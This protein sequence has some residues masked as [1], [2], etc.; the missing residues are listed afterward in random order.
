[1]SYYGGGSDSFAGIKPFEAMDVSRS[2]FAV[3]AGLDYDLNESFL[4][5][6]AA[7]YEDFSDFGSN[8]SWK[9]NTRYKL[10]KDI[11][12]RASASTGFRAPSLHQRY[13]TLTQYIIVAP[14]P[15]PQLQGTFANDSD[16]VRGLGVPNLEAETS[17]NYSVGVTG[18]AGK[19]SFSAD[20]YQISVDNR[21]LFSS[22]IGYDETAGNNPVE[23]ILED[24]GIKALQFFINAVNTK[25]TGADIVAGYNNVNLGK[26]K[27]GVNLAM[28]F[29]NTEMDGKVAN[30]QVLKE[31]GYSVF[32]HREELRITDA[33]P[34]SKISLGLDYSINNFNFGLNNTR[35]GEV[36]VAG[37]VA[38]DDQVH[39]AKIATD[40]TF[41][42]DFSKSFSLSLAANNI[43]DV[44]P[45]I[46]DKNL[47]SAGGRFQYS[48][49]VTQIGQLGTNYS[50]GLK[51]KF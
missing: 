8:F 42:Y 49:E 34:K 33:R 26:G 51:L 43:F 6:G 9:L 20:V 28:N 30:P 41:G 3:Y 14:N 18:K 46:L 4:V 45:D 21:V 31:N 5:G 15:D 16:I 10:T 36:T 40:F 47:R 37:E 13:I 29:N 2:N 22:Q 25:T 23:Q 50:L 48:S 35:F 39:A 12:L 19:L 24:N 32:N 7:R 44:Y 11:A 17:Q 38:E 27:F 1:M